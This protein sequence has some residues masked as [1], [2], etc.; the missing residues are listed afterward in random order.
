M[1]LTP[2]GIRAKIKAAL[3]MD[4]PKKKEAYKPKVDNTPKFTLVVTNGQGR[5]EKLETKINQTL[6]MA[7]GDL[8]F[9]IGSG[10]SDSTCSTCRVEVL[11]GAE[12]LTP[13]DEKEAKTLS[14]NNREGALRLACITAVVKPG[15]VKLR[16][17]EFLE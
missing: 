13:Q 5:E 12:L 10:C 11:E 14:E 2:F 16:A 17:F 1:G 15:T 7:S 3:G 4:A 6:L 9:P 8:E